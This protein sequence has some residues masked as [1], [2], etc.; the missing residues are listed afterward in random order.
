M[1]VIKITKAKFMKHAKAGL[2]YCG[3]AWNQDIDKIKKNLETEDVTKYR[4]P[5]QSR[6]AV[7]S[8]QRIKLI[9]SDGE[10]SYIDIG[11]QTKEGVTCHIE[12][13]GNFLLCIT[14]YVTP[15]HE[16]GLTPG[17]VTTN[18]VVYAKGE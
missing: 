18:I 6:K 8:G 7:N 17:E 4:N 11:N 14:K 5:A 15:E 10:F 9:K 13:I 2:Y 12:E 1:P 16:V 3:S